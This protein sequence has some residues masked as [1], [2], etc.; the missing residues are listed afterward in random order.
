MNIV[1]TCLTQITS[2]SIINTMALHFE[3]KHTVL[4]LSWHYIL[5]ENKPGWAFRG[6]KF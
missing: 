1:K 4:G 3:R 5:S 6:T 2:T